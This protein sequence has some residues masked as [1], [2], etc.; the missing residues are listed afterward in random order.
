MVYK[1]HCKLNSMILHSA[2]VNKQWIQESLPVRQLFII[3]VLYVRGVKAL[4][5][6]ADNKHTPVCTSTTLPQRVTYMY[7]LSTWNSGVVSIPVTTLHDNT[8]NSSSLRYKL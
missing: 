4:T 7:I 5:R 1:L 8:I 6:L 3:N 2:C